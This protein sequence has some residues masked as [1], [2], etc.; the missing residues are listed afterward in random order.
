MYGPKDSRARPVYLGNHSLTMSAFV[1]TAA[2]RTTGKRSGSAPAPLVHDVAQRLPGDEAAQVVQ[3]RLQ[4]PLR[5]ARR[6]GGAVRRDDDIFHPPQ[7]MVW[8]QRLDL[9][10]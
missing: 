2:P 3:Q 10:D 4:V 5:H 9:E 1:F 8:R 7:R 6:G